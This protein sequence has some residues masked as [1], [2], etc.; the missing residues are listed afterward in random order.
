LR[1]SVTGDNNFLMQSIIR[2]FCHATGLCQHKTH[3]SFIPKDESDVEIERLRAA[4]EQVS[5][6]CRNLT[7]K[8]IPNIKAD[9]EVEIERLREAL[10]DMLAGWRY[11]RQTHGELY[12]VGW[13]RCEQSASAALKEQ[14]R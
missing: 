7:E 1:V 9:A 14:E 11:I 5:N 13:D 2:Q 3:A 10:R 6:D 4:Y 12:G 8:V